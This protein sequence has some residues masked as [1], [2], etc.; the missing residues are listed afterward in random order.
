M[1]GIIL[2][3]GSGTRLFPATQVINKQ[4][5]PIYDK[6]MIYYPLS[7][8][9]LGGIREILLITT[10]DMLPLFRNLFGDG[11]TLGLS[12]QYAEQPQPNGLAEAFI[13]GRDFIGDDDCALILGDNIFYGHG[14]M[15]LLKKASGRSNGATIFAYWVSNPEA[16]GVVDLDAEGKAMKL[17]EKPTNPTSNWAVTGLYFFDNKVVD[18]AAKV[19]PSGRGELEIT[20]VIHAYME[21]DTL[22]VELM[23]RGFAW[24][25]TGTHETLLQASQFVQTVEHR[26]GLKIACL[27]EIALRMNFIDMD[28]FLRIANEKAGSVYGNY[29]LGVAKEVES[30]ISGSRP[31]SGT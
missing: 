17:V 30:G 18:I 2:A 7:A 4:L 8:L 21:T 23:G 16:Y 13:I 27:E 3:G 25:D 24:L 28:A 22:N 6:P 19:T 14:F 29:L 31:T 10:P 5:L 1:K 26:Q 12:I 20:D 11:S 15:D 9:M